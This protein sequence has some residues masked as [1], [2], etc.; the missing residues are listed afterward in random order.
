M[1]VPMRRASCR[2]HLLQSGA[3][4]MGFSGKQLSLEAFCDACNTS[5]DYEDFS[6]RCANGEHDICLPC[7]WPRIQEYRRV[8]GAVAAVAESIGLDV[9]TA[10]CVVEYCVGRMRQFENDEW[11]AREGVMDLDDSDDDDDDED[12]EM[13]DSEEGSTDEGSTD[14]D[15]DAEEDWDEGRV[16]VSRYLEWDGETVLAWILS[17]DNGR[18]RRYEAVLRP[19]LSNHN[20]T[21]NDLREG[22]ITFETVRAMG[23]QTED[24]QILMTHIRDLN[25]NER[26]EQQQGQGGGWRSKCCMM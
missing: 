5:M 22:G 25:A 9:Y 24:V 3:T 16:D 14:D 26:P 12:E 15:G 23:V 13:G 21:G 18:F 4:S 7:V 17:L 10:Q 6:F 19:E 8:N 2:Q 11:D 1:N 20:I